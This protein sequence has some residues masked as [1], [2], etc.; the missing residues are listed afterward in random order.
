MTT[1]ERV[2]ALKATVIAARNYREA[3]M[4]QRRVL[5]DGGLD[6]QSWAALSQLLGQK[7]QAAAEALDTALAE[8]TTVYGTADDYSEQQEVR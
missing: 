3:I 8:L 6:Y 2:S 4:Q 1:E 5:F 7:V